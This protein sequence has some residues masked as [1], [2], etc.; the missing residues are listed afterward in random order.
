MAEKN[1][2]T[3]LKLN[4]KFSKLSRLACFKQKLM[5]FGSTPI[6]SLR[7]MASSRVFHLQT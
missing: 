5:Q 3:G 1:G 6:S 4:D 2:L 7:A